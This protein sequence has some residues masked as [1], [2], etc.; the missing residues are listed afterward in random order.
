VVRKASRTIG[1]NKGIPAAQ[2]NA[3]KKWLGLRRS[4]APIMFG[5]GPNLDWE[6]HRVAYGP[7]T[8][9]AFSDA[10]KNSLEYPGE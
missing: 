5:F 1:L 3:H 8:H 4:R 9:M 10:D 2:R 7:G 6:I